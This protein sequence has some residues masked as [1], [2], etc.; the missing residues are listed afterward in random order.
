MATKI[1]SSKLVSVLMPVYNGR[2]FIRESVESILNQTHTNWELFVL[3]DGSTDDCLVELRDIYDSRIKIM[4]ESINKGIVHQ[5]NKG[6]ELSAGEYI[7][8]MDSDDISFPE[9]LEKQVRFLESNPRIDVLGSQAEKFGEADGFTNYPLS[10]KCIDYLLNYYCPILHPSVM[11][12]RE[13][14]SSKFHRYT[15]SLFAEDY[16]LWIDVSSGMNIANM[17]DVLIRYRIH[18]GQTNRNKLRHQYEGALVARK[19]K[20][21]KTFRFCNEAFIS[22]L[23]IYANDYIFFGQNIRELSGTRPCL[24]DK[25][26]FLYTYFLNRNC[27]KPVVK[28]CLNFVKHR[29][30]R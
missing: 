2:N 8:R 6:I 13:L 12:R 4:R 1:K 29:L 15:N 21:M 16:E 22:D 10:P 25:F 11:M 30:L 26:I 5:L 17:Q 18:G 3:D 20:L 19:K 9:R 14:F 23:N 27:S 24:K 7:A 28:A